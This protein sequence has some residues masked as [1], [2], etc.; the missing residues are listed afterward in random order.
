MKHLNL[1]AAITAMASPMFH[2]A[3]AT[4]GGG[5]SDT[6]DAPGRRKPEY[7]PVEMTDG[8]TVEFTANIKAKKAILGT[9]GQDLVEGAEP[10]GVR[11]DFANGQTRSL[12]LSDVQALVNRFAVHGLS[13]KG[14]DSYASE[15]DVD[16]AVEALDDTL[17]MLREG[18]WSEGRTGGFGG[19]S[20]LVKALAEVY[21]KDLDTV[22]TILKDLSPKDKQQLRQADGVREVVQRLEQEK[23]AASGVDTDKLLGLFTA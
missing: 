11:F 9:D 7:I 16:D 1:F 13:Q 6:P 2:M 23:A 22:R 10:G 17:K 12:L 21:G 19:V 8:R 3:E 15:K 4:D 5:S 20:I 18:K 14:G